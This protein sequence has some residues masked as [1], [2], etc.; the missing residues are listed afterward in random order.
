MTFF[1]Q[2][3]SDLVFCWCVIYEE[4]AFYTATF[5]FLLFYS[6]CVDAYREKSKN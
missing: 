2:I 5:V 3:F 6:I 4:W 1:V